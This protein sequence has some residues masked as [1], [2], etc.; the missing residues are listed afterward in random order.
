MFGATPRCPRC[1][2]LVYAAEQILGPGRKF[3]HKP[4]LT[5]TIC[6]R[7]LD[8]YTLLEHDEE[9]YC[10]PCHLKNFGTRD[11]RHA[12]LPYAPRPRSSSTSTD[13]V[14]SPTSSPGRPQLAP[15]NTGDANNGLPLLRPTRV[16]SPTS[17]N[18]P[19]PLSRP[20]SSSGSSGNNTPV[21]FGNRA[22]N[23][24]PEESPIDADLEADTSLDSSADD[25]IT[26]ASTDPTSADEA[27]DDSNKSSPTD[28]V[29]PYLL[30]NTGRPGLGN[31]PR[32]VPL[33]LDHSAHVS[34]RHKTTQSLGSIS[35][36]S[37]SPPPSSFSPGSNRAANALNL[38]Q[39]E[40][41]SPLRQTPTGTRYGAALGPGNTMSL[42]VHMTG[43]GGSPRKWGGT[44]PVCPKCSKNVYF[45]EQV[46]AVGK[47]YHKFCLRCTECTTTLD[48]TKL[49]D[50][51]GE[52]FCVRCY[53]KLHGPQ[54]HGYA[55]L[56]KAG[57]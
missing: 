6:K 31:L 36:S 27:S 45:A 2:K 19:R 1:E 41:M 52:P 33:S 37:S 15:L 13:D 26:T 46:K 47:T 14:S 12:N 25:S 11:L 10:K 7:R 43:T 8:S 34:A 48:S 24:I 53:N 42:G 38:L 57:G 51:D 54:G 32:T 21:P 50:H 5:C 55:L 20:G 22:T 29:K 49:R 44:T 18:F 4:C 35:T 17:S 40:G 39:Q 9:P 23:A 28:N 3:Y 16:L 56:G 30:T